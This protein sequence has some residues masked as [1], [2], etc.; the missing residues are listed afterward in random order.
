MST[1]ITGVLERPNQEDQSWYVVLA[2]YPNPQVVVAFTI[3]RAGFGAQA[4]A[5]AACR[6]LQ[7]YFGKA[8]ESKHGDTCT[9]PAEAPVAGGTAF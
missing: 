3:E 2:P 1:A 9:G 6:V 5:P 4:A 7:A 8:A